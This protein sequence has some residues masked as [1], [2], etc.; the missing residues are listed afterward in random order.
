MHNHNYCFI[1]NEN[2]DVTKNE[3]T[4]NDITNN[5]N[6]VDLAVEENIDINHDGDTLATAKEDIITDQ[7]SHDIEAGSHG[8]TH[9]LD[10]HIETNN[11]K[12]LSVNGLS[13]RKLLEKEE[14]E[15]REENNT[16]VMEDFTV[17]TCDVTVKHKSGSKFMVKFKLVKDHAVTTFLIFLSLLK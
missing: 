13:Y 12:I 6:I 7:N 9:T 16:I 8:D 14:L 2:D 15:D 1:R 5:G 11:H 3:V 10:A 4:D 17:E